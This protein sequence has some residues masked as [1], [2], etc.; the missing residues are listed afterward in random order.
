MTINRVAL[1]F[2]Y[3]CA[4]AGLGH[5]LKEL[6]DGAAGYQATGLELNP[7][8]VNFARDMFGIRMLRGRVEQ[9][10]IEWVIGCN[11]DDGR[12]RASAQ[13]AQT[14]PTVSG[15]PQARWSVK[16]SR[17]RDIPPAPATRRCSNREIDS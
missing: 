2:F 17:P 6:I 13:S 11:R 1:Q 10:Y 8:L 5:G 3:S 14:D 7:W 4:G 12:H 16:S 15:T 9:Q